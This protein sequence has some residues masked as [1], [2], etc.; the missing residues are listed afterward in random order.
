MLMPGV[1]RYGEKRSRLPFEADALCGVVP[2]RGRTAAVE[3]KNHFFE[4]LP[5]RSQFLGWRNFA[6]IAIVR[7]ARR[8]VVDEYAASTPPRPR[9]QLDR[10]QVGHVM[11]GN[12][13]KPF[14][15]DPERVR[16][17]FLRR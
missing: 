11:R 13:L 12:D 9:L 1:E 2:H 7:S 10:V 17:F 15:T 8:L 16:R 5:L 3:H 4:Q 6:D 14:I